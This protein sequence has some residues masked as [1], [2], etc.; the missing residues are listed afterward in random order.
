MANTINSTTGKTCE[1]I[2]AEL[3]TLVDK[4]NETT[5]FLEKAQIKLEQAKLVQD[6]NETSL[7]D[8]YCK[9][10]E[11]STP[12]RELAKRYYYPTINV[13]DTVHKETVDGK[14]KATVAQSI[15]DSEKALDVQKFIEWASE[16]HKIV[17][18]NPAWKS[19]VNNCR[20]AIENV[21]KKFFASKGNTAQISKLEVISATQ[22][23]FN[24]LLGEGEIIA[25][26]EFAKWF[27]AF[28]NDRKVMRTDSGK[29]SF[30]GEIL[31]YRK[32]SGMLL[33]VLHFAVENCSFT[34]SYGTEAEAAKAKAKAEAE[35][36]TEEASEET[37]E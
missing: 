11:A 2:R 24:D 15:T 23:M 9:C 26:Q 25:T 1:E 19:S 34:V 21:W 20:L 32:W 37:A 29:I 5:D 13:K 22:A 18:A 31:S 4:Y 7:V 12:L 14:L 28:A 27:I 36:A 6:F 8:T 10:T 16:G 35:E 3:A 30:S 17:T 33:D